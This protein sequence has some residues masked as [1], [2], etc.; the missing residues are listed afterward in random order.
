[1]KQYFYNN[2]EQYVKYKAIE[3]T[4]WK[5]KDKITCLED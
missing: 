5:E 2:Q 1:M 4:A 3:K